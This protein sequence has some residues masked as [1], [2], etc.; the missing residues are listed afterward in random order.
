MGNLPGLH[1]QLVPPSFAL[2][3]LLMT[4]EGQPVAASTPSPTSSS[5]PSATTATSRVI[6]S[7]LTRRRSTCQRIFS[8]FTRPSSSLYDRPCSRATSSVP[9]G[10]ADNK[11]AEPAP[12]RAPSS[13]HRSLMPV[14]RRY[15]ARGSHQGGQEEYLIEG[16]NTCPYLRKGAGKGITNE[17]SSLIAPLRLAV[18]RSPQKSYADLLPRCTLASTT[19]L[20]STFPASLFPAP[21]STCATVTT[22]SR[23]RQRP[24][25]LVASRAPRRYRGHLLLLDEKIPALQASSSSTLAMTQGECVQG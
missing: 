4:K 7:W 10:G 6:E 16:R 19:S 20:H 13:R 9:R 14:T 2:S 17:F 24:S 3:R 23:Q 12:V 25:T 11:F 15:V 1:S 22:D 8:V 5:S 21:S 18:H